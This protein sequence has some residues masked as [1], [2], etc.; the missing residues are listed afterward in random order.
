[1]ILPDPESNLP[2]FAA[3]PIVYCSVKYDL[4]AAVTHCKNL[5]ISPAQKQL[6]AIH[7]K[8]GHYDINKL[9]EIEGTGTFPSNIRKRANPKCPHF[10]PRQKTR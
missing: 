4:Q 9:R 5:N 2:I 3:S 8:F 7:Y 10:I 1:M 6:L